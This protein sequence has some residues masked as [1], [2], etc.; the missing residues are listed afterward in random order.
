[1]NYIINI[2]TKILKE[3]IVKKIIPIL[4][5]LD[6]FEWVIENII[7]NSIDAIAQKGEI[8]IEVIEKERFVIIDVI[9]NGK[10]IK[11][12]FFNEIFKPGFT[13]KKRGWGLGLSLVKRIIKDYHK[14]EVKIQK[15]IPNKET[16]VRI[17]LNK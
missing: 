17:L 16:V 10:G 12:Y 15:S 3:I 9:D 13:S 8:M 1:M 4:I 6:L 14:G 5:N 7:K 2:V 11:K